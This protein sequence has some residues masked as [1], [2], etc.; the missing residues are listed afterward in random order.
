[1]NTDM[2]AALFVGIDVGSAS[3]RAGVFD[4]AGGKRAFAV[5]PILQANPR[6]FFYE[7]STTDIWRQT[8][9][10][11][12]EA[13]AASGETASM[14]RGIGFDATCSLAV[15][16]PGGRPV[17]VAEDGDP[18]RNIIMW[19]DHR[20]TAEAAEI[21]ATSDPALAYVGGEVGVE[22]ELPKVLWLHRH[23]AERQQQVWRY[24]DLADYMVWRACGSDIAS[25]CTLTC[26][27]NYLA[28]EQRFSE[29]LLAA[30][31]L[32]HLPR[33]VPSVVLQLG[34]AAGRLS[35]KAAGE[36]GLP[37][38]IAVATGII[39]AHAGGVALCGA[40]PQGSLAVISGT[41]CCHLVASREAVMV[42]G[43]WGPYFGAMLPGWWLNEGGQSAAGSLLDWTLRQADAWPEL[44]VQARREGRSVHAVAGDWVAALQSR[45]SEPTAALHVLAD[46]Y[47]NRSPRADPTARGMMA[48]LTLESGP[49]ALARRYLATVQALAYGTRHIIDAMNAAGHR[50]ERLLI[51]GG[52]AKNPLSLREHADATGCD[53]E[54]ASEEDA[55]TLGSAV[56]AA[57]ACGAYTD[58]Q[59][60][61]SAMVHP[62][63]VL[64]ANPARRHFHDAKY[65]VYLA[66][67]A[68]WQHCQELM[69]A[70]DPSATL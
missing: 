52:G 9:A 57:T 45:E 25:V 50:I 54:L 60:A 29:S 4:A 37:A 17:S 13:L 5:R 67:Y 14:V 12:R 23:Q 40:R 59:A 43:V 46:H 53:L 18:E 30:V 36:L 2:N 61:A 20:A 39:D 68:D 1:M 35:E 21:N 51:T 6:P 44:E 28:H 19:M 15:V 56:L 34:S 49:D 47:G 66:L 63:R 7:Q 38:G 10:A 64:R 41:S 26:K 24:F 55:V 32:S 33:R 58:L 22:M 42:P 16:G 48:G 70:A 27:W 31:G 69:V 3:V 8:A 11:V 65:R 62:A